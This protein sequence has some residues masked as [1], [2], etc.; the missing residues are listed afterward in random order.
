LARV[1]ATGATSWARPPRSCGRPGA[2]SPHSAPATYERA[3]C[4]AVEPVAESFGDLDPR[5]DARV[6]DVADRAKWRG[7]HRIE[8]I[9]CVRGTT[10]GAGRYGAQLLADVAELHRRAAGIDYQPVLLASGAVEET[11]DRYRRTMPLG[12][13][14]ARAGR[15]PRPR[16]S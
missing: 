4:E 3:N 1:T 8:Q 12:Y 5:I 2:S 9:L 13:A 16:G 14:L 15:P 6:N 10:A 7:F 11:L